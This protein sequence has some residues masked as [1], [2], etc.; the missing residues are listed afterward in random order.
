MFP[1]VA[2]LAFFSSLLTPYDLLYQ[3]PLVCWWFLSLQ[4][5]SWSLHWT[6]YLHVRLSAGNLH[7]DASPVLK[8]QRG[9][10]WTQLSQHFKSTYLFFSLL[11]GV[12]SVNPNPKHGL[13]CHS[14][15]GPLSYS[16]LS[17]F[18]LFFIPCHAFIHYFMISVQ[19]NKFTKL[20]L[21][22]E[23]SY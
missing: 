6:S 4:F 16:Y 15:R 8:V 17:V 23:P 9:Q 20:K 13:L 7:V 21:T 10:N 19:L 12:A 1:R 14:A 22:F 2:P 18:L 5:S 11:S 3:P